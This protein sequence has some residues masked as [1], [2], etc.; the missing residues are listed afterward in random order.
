MTISEK[1]ICEGFLD[2]MKNETLTVPNV[3]KQ[4]AATFESRASEQMLLLR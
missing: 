4:I 1:K 2:H 3:T